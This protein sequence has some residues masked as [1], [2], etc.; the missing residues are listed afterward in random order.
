M[1]KTKGIE[2]TINPR[3]PFGDKSELFA[4]ELLGK[5]LVCQDDNVKLGDASG[6]CAYLEKNHPDILLY[7]TDATDYVNALWLE[8]YANTHLTATLYTVF[9]N[10]CSV[11]RC[12]IHPLM[13]KSLPK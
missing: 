10:E 6:I 4:L 1:L 9:F 7:P 11:P 12:L 13:K 8:K 3:V 5:I 2:Y